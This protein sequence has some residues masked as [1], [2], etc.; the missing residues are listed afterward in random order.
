MP[1]NGMRSLLEPTRFL[2][3]LSTE[4]YGARHVRGLRG[5][6][7][8]TEHAVTQGKYPERQILYNTKDQG[9]GATTPTAGRPTGTSPTDAFNPTT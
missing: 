9:R 7:N 4:Q 3:T 6:G 8:R 2:T 1:R 5:L